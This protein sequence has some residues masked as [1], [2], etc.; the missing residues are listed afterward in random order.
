MGGSGA[1]Q[2]IYHK[3]FLSF[4]NSIKPSPD[5]E[6]VDAASMR[7]NDFA[8]QFSNCHPYHG[9]IVTPA[10]RFRGGRRFNTGR[11]PT[12][13]TEASNPHTLASRAP[14]APS[15]E[16]QPPAAE[17]IFRSLPSAR[18]PAPVDAGGAPFASSRGTRRRPATRRRGIHSRLADTELQRRHFRSRGPGAGERDG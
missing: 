17:I 3:N 2:G 4:C 15:D 1:G 16:G 18:A 9:S 12:L 7:T 13:F 10:D 8:S 14:R 5:Q 11:G 6:I